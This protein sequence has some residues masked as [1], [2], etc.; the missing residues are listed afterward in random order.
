MNATASTSAMNKKGLKAKQHPRANSASRDGFI[1]AHGAGTMWL[2]SAEDA[3][4]LGLP[5]FG[6]VAEVVSASDGFSESTP[7]PGKGLLA[8]EKITLIAAALEKLALSGEDIAV[9]YQHG[10]STKANDLNEAKLYNAVLQI[11]KKKFGDQ[12]VMRAQKN[13]TGHGKGLAAVLQLIGMLQTLNTGTIAGDRNLDA[14]DPEF[15]S[16][17]LLGNLLYTNHTVDF[18]PFSLMAGLATSLGF[19]HEG[20]MAL[21]VN[22]VLVLMSMTAPQRETYYAKLD[23]RM[24]VIV[25]AEIDYLMGKR[26]L[27]DFAKGYLFEGKDKEARKKAQEEYLG[28]KDAF[29]FDP[30]KAVFVR[31]NEAERRVTRSEKKADTAK[32]PTPRL[33]IVPSVVRGG[34]DR[35]ERY[36]PD[37]DAVDLSTID[38]TA[39]AVRAPE[40]GGAAM[41]GVAL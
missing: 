39:S 25:Q 8:K 27:Y 19:G 38:I 5:M 2:M 13:I 11:L 32:V 26:G 33:R 10:T 35:I 36:W 23:E 6:I 9:I 1:E 29:V 17:G 21:L 41:V 4:A 12:A 7:E 31:R 15:A 3:I 34:H 37:P 40:A 28:D 14:V 24:R 20:V 30:I 18:G 22:P 16:E